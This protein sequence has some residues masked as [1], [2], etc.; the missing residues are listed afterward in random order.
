MITKIIYW[1]GV[2]AGIAAGVVAIVG[3][4]ITGQVAYAAWGA[5]AIAGSI[6]AAISGAKAR[7]DGSL[8]PL[9]IGA[10]FK[11]IPSG[12]WA[13]IAVLF[14]A[15]IVVTIIFPPFK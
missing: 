3:A 7:P 12:A 10:I 13:A 14:V 11:E 4:I 9:K 5:T 2:C 1:A 8:S 6:L 15:S